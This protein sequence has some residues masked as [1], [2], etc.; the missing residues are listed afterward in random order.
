MVEPLPVSSVLAAQVET[1]AT[2]DAPGPGDG[3]F[4][5]GGGATASPSEGS[6]SVTRT[7]AALQGGNTV[8][9]NIDNPSSGGEL[10]CSASMSVLF[11]SHQLP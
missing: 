9:L 6:F 3:E 7:L 4:E 2:D 1:S 8:Y 5:I 10:Y 11:T